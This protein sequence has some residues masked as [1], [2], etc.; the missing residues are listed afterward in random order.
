MKMPRRIIRLTNNPCGRAGF[1]LIEILMAI[2]IL[3]IILSALYSTFFLSHKAM[4]GLDESLVKLQ[5][6]RAMMDMLRREGDSIF[7]S[8]GNK[9]CI[10]KME[11]RDLYGKQASRWVFTAFSPIIPGLSMIS[12]EV[13]EV[14]GKPMILKKIRSAYQ[15]EGSEE[16]AEMIEEVEAFAVEARDKERWV[17]QW[18]ASEIKKIPEEIRVTITVRIKDRPITLYET[19]KPKIGKTL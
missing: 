13:E 1:T 4:E 7:Y 8:L 12:Y 14:A 18:D 6:C 16:G 11:D 9:N 2:A 19:I 3:S 15:S 5:E 17:K 10:F